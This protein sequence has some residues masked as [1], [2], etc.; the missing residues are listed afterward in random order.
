M[1]RVLSGI[2]LVLMLLMIG[3]IATCSLRKHFLA[4]DPVVQPA[5][6]QVQASAKPLLAALDAFHA[7]HGYFPA[8]PDALSDD[9]ALPAG[10]VYEVTNLSRV[11]RSLACANR[12]HEFNGVNL[13]A[14]D[15][16]ARLV[17][18]LHECVEGYSNFTLRSARL[19]TSKAV[20]SN[21]LAYGKFESM[22]GEWSVD[23]C[24]ANQQNGVPGDCRQ[25]PMNE[26]R[27]FEDPSTTVAGRVHAHHVRR[28]MPVAPAPGS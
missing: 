26:S 3:G 16:H 23:W 9:A 21:L 17:A 5:L 10:F 8:S 25:T 27:L 20:N 11:Y 2:G 24:Q 13:A 18:W 22:N 1:L 14:P 7:E 28:P 15:T 12:T 6:E 4:G 19:P